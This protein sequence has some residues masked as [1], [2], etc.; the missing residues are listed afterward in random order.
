MNILVTLGFIWSCV[1]YANYAAIVAVNR[2]AGVTYEKQ[3]DMTVSA[4][5]SQITDLSL[6]SEEI[7]YLA[8]ITAEVYASKAKPVDE[9]KRVYRR[10]VRDLGTPI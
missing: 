4:I 7:S 1:D 8:K 5:K 10:C 6:H 2:D 9:A 3:V